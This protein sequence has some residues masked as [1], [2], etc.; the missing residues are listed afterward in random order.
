MIYEKQGS[1]A[2]ALEYHQRAR[3]IFARHVSQDRLLQCNLD[4]GALYYQLGEYAQAGTVPQPLILLGDTTHLNVRAQIDEKDAWR[5][6]QG[7]HAKASIR[8]DGSRGFELEFV[9]VEPYV[10]PKRNLTGESTERVDTRVLEAIYALPAGAPVYPGQQ[11]DVAIE[12][13]GGN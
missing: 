6:R 3:E 13:K 5:F 8:G 12:V 1:F 11:M 10:I 4:L 9:R 7:A 2:R